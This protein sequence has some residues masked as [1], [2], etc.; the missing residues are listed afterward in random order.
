MVRFSEEVQVTREILK[1]KESGDWRQAKIPKALTLEAFQVKL[2][3]RGGTFVGLRR[4]TSFPE[5][6]AAAF[7]DAFEASRK[8]AGGSG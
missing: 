2:P 4:L 5:A 7:F 3:D 1:Q 8:V 6:E